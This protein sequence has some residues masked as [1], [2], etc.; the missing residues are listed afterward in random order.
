[1]LTGCVCKRADVCVFLVCKRVDVGH[2]IGEGKNDVEDA[3]MLMWS[4]WRELV[5]ERMLLCGSLLAVARWH[6]CGSHIRL[7]YCNHIPA[8][9]VHVSNDLD[10]LN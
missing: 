8:P 2:F 1:M 9:I 4:M 6:S 10:Q 5:A 3:R 7:Q